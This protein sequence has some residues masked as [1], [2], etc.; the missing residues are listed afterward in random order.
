MDIKHLVCVGIITLM[1]F[2]SV[3]TGR[4]MCYSC[5]YNF[6]AL[7]NGYNCVTYPKN[8][9]VGDWRM[10]CPNK[11]TES[12]H[13]SKE[14]GEATYFYRGCSGGDEVPEDGCTEDDL[15]FY[16][17]YSCSG[18][19]CNDGPAIDEELFNEIKQDDEPGSGNVPI[20]SWML[21]DFA[22]LMAVLFIH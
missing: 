1:S 22:F 9:T 17:F 4:Q 19:Y 2:L 3:A 12:S 11:C 16:C 7:K 20:Y 10:R 8:W 18:H 14:T 13:Y 15:K 21:T 6:N 5:A